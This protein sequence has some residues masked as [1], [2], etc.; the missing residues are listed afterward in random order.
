MQVKATGSAITIDRQD[1]QIAVTYTGGTLNPAGFISSI[2]AYDGSTLLK[3]MPLSS[4]DFT[5]DSTV[6]YV[7]MI[8][9][10]FNVPAGTTKTLTFKINTSALGSADNARTLTVTGYGTQGTR[11]V[12]GAGL[13]SYTDADWT[14]TFAFNASNNSTLTASASSDTPLAQTIA[15]NTTDGVQGVVMQKVD[16]KS[17]IGDSTL[18]DL[19]V[20][21]E[22]NG[23]STSVPTALFLYNG[24]PSDA[25]LLGSA[26]V[27]TS[28][29]N[30]S[31]GNVNFT[32]LSLDIAKN[33]TKTLTVTANFPATAVGIASTTIGVTS[34]SSLYETSD[35]TSNNIVVSSAITG[36]DV[37]L[38]AADATTY[39]L[40]SSSVTSERSQLASQ[41]SSVTGTIVLN[42][43]SVGGALT[44]PT[45]GMFDVW[46][47]SSTPA[48]TTNG[49]T[50]YAAATGSINVTPTI[51][52]TP[53]ASTLTDGTY[54]ITIT[55]TLYSTNASF[56]QTAGVG[57][58]EYMAI[59]SI[60]TTM[61]P[62]GGSVSNQDWG[63]DTFITPSAKLN[64]AAGS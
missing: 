24:T 49:G 64:E 58:S 54:T 42:A 53:T 21:V 25:N 30:Y 48:K 19:R 52:V 56:V 16:L 45:A 26:A 15:V 22:T 28:T 37:H 41:P 17:T 4:A 12:D 35:G 8:G 11:G 43:K 62:T 60:D 9:I 27:A 51:Q 36:N 2:S 20:V 34:A 63:M 6:Y 55:G 5:K 32:N 10:G 13:S 18:T 57:F 44:K 46:F 33:A 14:S 40:V 3:T 1:L 61:D 23:D 59:D 31:Y 47:A 39:T 50:G 7:R 38:M 29:G